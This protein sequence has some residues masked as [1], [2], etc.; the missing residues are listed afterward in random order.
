MPSKRSF[1]FPL[2]AVICALGFVSVIAV[3]TAALLEQRAGQEALLPLPIELVGL[4]IPMVFGLVT[5]VLAAR[6]LGGARRVVVLILGVLLVVWPVW[7]VGGAV[8]LSC[9]GGLRGVMVCD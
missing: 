4:V 3:M 8:L 5:I 2:V 6:R 1:P 7:A 9:L